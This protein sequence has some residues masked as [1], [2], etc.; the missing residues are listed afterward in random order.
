MAILASLRLEKWPEY[1]QIRMFKR[2][3]NCFA[4]DGVVLALDLPQDDPHL[5]RLRA[6]FLNQY[7]RKAHHD[8][9]LDVTW[10]AFV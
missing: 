9:L 7:L 8:A 5:M 3:L 2:A 10:A 6:D 1:L 4:T